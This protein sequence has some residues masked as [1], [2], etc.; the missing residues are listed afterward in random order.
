MIVV[1]ILL[2]LLML[3]EILH[4]LNR[5]S[6]L[7]NIDLAGD[8]VEQVD[9]ETKG[10]KGML[11]FWIR[12]L[13]LFV[14]CLLFA[15]IAAFSGIRVMYT[16]AGQLS[17]LLIL[18][19]VVRILNR[20]VV[21][22][23][24]VLGATVILQVIL[25]ILLIFVGLTPEPSLHSHFH[26]TA[27]LVSLVSFILLFLLSVMLPFTATYYLRLLS[28]EGSGLYYFMPPLAYSEYWIRRLVRKAANT[29]LVSLL[30]LAYLILRCGYPAGASIL[31]IVLVLL[32]FSALSLFRNR[33][34]LHHPT[35]IFLITFAWM[36]NV[37]W[38]LA[39]LT[40]TSSTWIV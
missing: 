18:I 20:K 7:M 1:F 2:F 23:W 27:W 38:V 34:K 11:L 5:G 21:N 19:Q 17:G 14:F 4:R 31:S 30:M 6:A 39:S 3:E 10:G 26:D 28:R 13:Q 32:L 16:S 9:Q 15:Y 8:S 22:Q 33:L 12:M 36:I 24:A 40:S 35:A 37:I 25:L 29:A